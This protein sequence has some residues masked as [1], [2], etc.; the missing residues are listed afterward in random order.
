MG[1]GGA[2][3]EAVA[4]EWESNE[5]ASIHILYTMQ[6]VLSK[7]SLGTCDKHMWMSRS[8]SLNIPTGSVFLQ[9]YSG[10]SNCL[11]LEE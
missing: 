7:G 11:K 3:A 6:R 1:E 4:E 2:E 10:C 9:S 8:H 5:A